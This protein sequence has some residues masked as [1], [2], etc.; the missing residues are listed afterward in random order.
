MKL[1]RL[2]IN[3]DHIATVRQARRSNEPDPVTA[4]SICEFAGADGITVHLRE[5]R[6]HIQDRDVRILRQTV[7][8]LLNL[9]CSLAG[10]IIDIACEVRPDEVCI[11]PENR[12]EI[13]TEGG[14]DAVTE[15]SR[16][17]KVVSRLKAA[18]IIVSIFVDPD[19]NQIKASRDAGADFIEIHTGVYSNA[20]AR[21]DGGS[22][23]NIEHE[24]ERLQKAAEAAYAIGLRVNAGHGIDYKNVGPIVN[25]PHVEELNIGFAI[26]AR[27]VFTGLDQAV[28]EMRGA[29]LNTFQ[30]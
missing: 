13:T 20:C 16:L 8:T 19:L 17:T 6:R 12:Q 15:S 24:V 14:L 2:H 9:E 25:L 30:L 23:I 18:G 26:I 3:I 10:E 21:H 1:P 11:V 5:D 29:M 28:R 27:S 4:A 7:R 22:D